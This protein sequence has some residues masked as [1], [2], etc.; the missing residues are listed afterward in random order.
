MREQQ[1][2]IERSQAEKSAELFGLD[3]DGMVE[4]D[5]LRAFRLHVRAAH[6]DTGAE[7]AEAAELIMSARKARGVL[8]RWLLEQPDALCA[9][10]GGSGWVNAGNGRVRP[11]SRC[12]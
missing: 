10:C 5:V 7:P 11:C 4:A 3:L 2:P 9:Q 1:R 12:G 6:P 8:L